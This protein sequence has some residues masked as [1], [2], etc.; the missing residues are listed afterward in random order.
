VTIWLYIAIP[1]VLYLWYSLVSLSHPHSL[2]STPLFWLVIWPRVLPQVGLSLVRVIASRDSFS[3]V[4]E[5]T[6]AMPKD[7]SWPTFDATAL[8]AEKVADIY[9]ARHG[10]RAISWLLSPIG[11][12]IEF[13]QFF[14]K[15]PR[16]CSSK[17]VEVPAQALRALNTTVIGYTGR[18]SPSSAVRHLPTSFR[19][20]QSRDGSGLR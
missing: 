10:V 16:F 9:S 6:D 12:D 4:L 19:E 20:S 5:N 17:R 8:E 7:R 15:H 13:E 11:K 18:L 14:G 3:K 2:Y 1:L